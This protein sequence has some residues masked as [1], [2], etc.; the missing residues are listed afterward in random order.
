[1]EINQTMTLTLTLAKGKVLML[2][3]KQELIIKSITQIVNYQN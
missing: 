2:M 1:M 3:M